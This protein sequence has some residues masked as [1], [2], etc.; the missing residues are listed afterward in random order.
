MVIL[1]SKRAFFK[2]ILSKTQ[3]AGCRDVTVPSVESSSPKI[4]F[5]LLAIAI[6][7]AIGIDGSEIL[8]RSW[9][10]R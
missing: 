7:F 10:F 6:A 1:L 8:C 4:P 3:G 5:C 9:F 2:P